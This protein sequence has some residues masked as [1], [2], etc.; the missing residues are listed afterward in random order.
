MPLDF[1]V[2]GLTRVITVVPVP[3]HQLICR[4]EPNKQ[5]TFA[6]RK[7][8]KRETALGTIAKGFGINLYNIVIT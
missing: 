8:F 1:K 7:L 6:V 3:L 5:N 4:H 2:P